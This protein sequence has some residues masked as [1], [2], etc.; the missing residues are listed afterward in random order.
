MSKLNCIIVCEKV[1]EYQLYLV[2]KN[3]RMHLRTETKDLEEKTYLFF[4]SL[5]I[6]SQL[7]DIRGYQDQM[8]IV[9]S[10]TE[11]LDR[12]KLNVF[13]HFSPIL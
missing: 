13:I 2:E 6:D 5:K 1:E 8:D 3:R 9:E 7:L 11:I 10:C 4:L 12:K